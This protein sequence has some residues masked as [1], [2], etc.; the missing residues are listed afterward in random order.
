MLLVILMLL[1]LPTHQNP[2]PHEPRLLTWQIITPASHQV[3]VQLTEQHPRGTWWPTLTV[4]ICTLFKQDPRHGGRIGRPGCG[5]R[6][7]MK[8]LQDTCFYV[9]PAPSTDRAKAS[10]CGGQTDFFCKN[11]GCEQTGTC[12]W[13]GRNA[14]SS[15]PSLI[16]VKRNS[17]QAQCMTSSTCNLIDISFTETGKEANWE[18]GLMWGLRLYQ[19]GYD[20]GVV[21]TLR[22]KVET[23]PA[24]P[25][26]PNAVLPDQPR[27]P[28]PAPKRTLTISAV[29]VFAPSP[30]TSFSSNGQ[31]LLNL[32]E[33]AFRVL[34]ATDPKTTESCWLCFSS[35]PP[36]YEGLGL[37]AD[38]KNT[39][40]HEICSWGSHKK[41]TLTEV[42]GI[43]KCLGTVPATHK[44]LCNETIPMIPTRENR[45]LVPP[46]EGWWACNT[47]LT[48]CV[49]TSVFNFS[50][51]FCIMVQLVPRLMYHDDFSFVAELEPRLRYKREPVS[52]TLAV[53]LGVGV[54]A[55]VGTGAAAI[56]Q[57]NQHYEGLRIAIDE[58][59]RTIEQ[60]ISKLEESLTSLSEVVLQN[61]RGLDLLFLKEGGLCAALKEEC[62]FYADHTGVVRDSMSKLRERLDQRKREREANQSLFESWFSRSPWLTTL[63]STLTGPLLIFILLLTL[64]PCILNRVITFIRERVSAVQVLMLRQQYHTLTHQEDT[65]IP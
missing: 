35:R 34:N 59:L 63:I 52:L 65:N 55:G 27:L 54:A 47:G 42:S 9:C 36:Y 7:S 5:S 28:T 4:D 6:A 24:I 18:K 33:G 58:D 19:E 50:H 17:T 22:L 32:V 1:L 60:S 12:H 20:N 30:L 44:N 31:R 57:E 61:R 2:N 39:T 45:Y 3:V 41:L 13:I 37:S 16:R 11:W 48:P 25:V 53:L 43:G 14:G 29:P 26:G 62:C 8:K 15:P 64:G 38:F 10:Q 23:L 56:I 40:S 46:P 51:E 21:F 49:S